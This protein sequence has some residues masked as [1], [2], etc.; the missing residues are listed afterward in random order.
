M[1][2]IYVCNSP[3][4]V[5]GDMSGSLSSSAYDISEINNFAV[6][7]VWTGTTPVGTVNVL[8]SNDGSNFDLLGTAVAISGNAG[9]KVIPASNAG[10]KY[11]KAVFT[12]TSGV[13]VLNASI[14]GKRI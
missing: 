5:A 4:I 6:Q 8:I 1:E 2:P 3:I 12:F 9:N 7:F 13:G 10:Y 14:S 11:V